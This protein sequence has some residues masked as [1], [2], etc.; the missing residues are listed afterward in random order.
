[1]PSDRTL[2]RTPFCCADCQPTNVGP[3]VNLKGF[4]EV[5][6]C[7][8]S[9]AIDVAPQKKPRGGSDCLWV[10]SWLLSKWRSCVHI[11]VEGIAS[12][13]CHAMDA[14]SRSASGDRVMHALSFD[15][16]SDSPG[17]LGI[18]RHSMASHTRWNRL[19]VCIAR[20]RVCARR[21]QAWR[22][23]LLRD[24]NCVVLWTYQDMETEDILR[25]ALLGWQRWALV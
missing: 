17:W 25:G 22:S 24:E 6:R 11:G 18:V 20:G 23:R 7:R 3:A 15:S 14:I 13:L 16:M 8:F 5:G 21:G 9:E 2:P 19:A 10:R 1:M 12:M 4:P